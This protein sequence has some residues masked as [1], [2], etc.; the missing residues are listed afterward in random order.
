[1]TNH[2]PCSVFILLGQSNAV[3]YSTLLPK[4]DRMEL[5]LKNVFGLTRENNLSYDNQELTWTGYTSHGTILGEENDHTCSVSNCL[6][7]C[8]QDAINEGADLPDLYILNISIGAQGVSPKYM[9]YPKREPML[10]PGPLGT[11]NISLCSFSNHIFSLLDDS[12]QKLGKSYEIMGIHWRGG[13]N[14]MTLP[15]EELT[16][17]L[18]PIYQ[19]LF[20]SFYDSLGQVPPVILH[21]LICEERAMVLDPTGEDLKSL[22]Y[23]D[24]IFH[25]LI[26]ENENISLF[27]VRKAPHYIPDTR[28]HGI[29]LE[30]VVHYTPETNQWVAKEIL[31]MY[32]DSMK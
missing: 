12:F 7:R 8:W 15:K 6:A 13:E 5:P 17:T 31:K 27:D 29:F 30:D 9:W 2:K 28:Q 25:E 1:M 23:I 3:G 22:H 14:D 21:K 11:A 26:E 10:V 19:D 32:I 16:G 24:T 20:K 4:E 18:K